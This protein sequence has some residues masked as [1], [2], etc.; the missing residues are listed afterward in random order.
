MRVL[1]HSRRRLLMKQ[2]LI[3][4]IGFCHDLFGPMDSWC[5]HSALGE[6]YIVVSGVKAEVVLQLGFVPK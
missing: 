1:I 2:K 4:Q 5:S 6:L 3:T